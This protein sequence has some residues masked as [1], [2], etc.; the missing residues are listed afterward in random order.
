M[1]CSF[2]TRCAALLMCCLL[3]SHPSSRADVY[4]ST[5]EK[6]AFRYATERLDA[7]FRLLNEEPKREVS[8]NKP[9]GDQ[10]RAAERRH[11]LPAGVLTALI[12]VESNF[13]PEAV[14]P[15][16]AIGLAQVMPATARMYGLEPQL[17][18][19]PSHN[20]DVGARHLAALIREYRGNLTLALAAYN[21]GS[22]NV[23]RARQR[24]PAL[25]ETMLYV[26][27][28]LLRAETLRSETP[29]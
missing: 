10:I 5:D 24:I 15:R 27:A 3:L 2:L 4:A 18:F 23:R 14:S 7:S 11:G 29:Q 13:Q 17:L 26:P 16:G 19:E 6:G 21:S 1:M 28:V 20:I 8:F 12:D 9:F 25:R 22:G